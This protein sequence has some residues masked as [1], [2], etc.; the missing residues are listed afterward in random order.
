MDDRNAQMRQLIALLNQA[1]DAYYNGRGELMSDFEW[2]AHFDQLKQLEQETGIVYPDS[3]TQRVSEDTI[4]G[5]K[6]EH[7]FP[8]L[9]LAKTKQTAE[10]A[11]WAEGRPIWISWKLDGLT[12]VV[13]YDDGR[14]AKV[15]TRGNGHIGTNITHHAAAIEGIPPTIPS[16]GHVVIR[17][18]AV[19]SYQDFE[20]FNMESD[21]EYANPRNLASGSLTL[22]DIDEVRRRHIRWIPFTLVHTDEEIASWGERMDWLTRQGL[23]TVEHELIAH[24][25]VAAIDHVIG[26]WTERVTE[27]QNP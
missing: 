21:E 27:R 8:A 23:A 16:H 18:E 2:D 24:P 26:Q 13:T 19:I 14:L 22:K 17:G 10:L 15:V 9:S 7:E 25:D 5:Q 1:S 6:E 11:R 12:L 4:A 3:P 20:Q